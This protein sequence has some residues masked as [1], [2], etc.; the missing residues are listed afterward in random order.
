MGLPAG[1][2]LRASQKRVDQ[3]PIPEDDVFKGLTV[4]AA[5]MGQEV[6]ITKHARVV[7]EL[8]VRVEVFEHE[9]RLQ[10]TVRDIEAHI[11]RFRAP[12]HERRKGNGSYSGI[13]RRRRI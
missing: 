5:Q 1:L 12:S 2:R 11:E 6:V 8:R 7:D 10:T 9:E 13:E 3:G 4:E